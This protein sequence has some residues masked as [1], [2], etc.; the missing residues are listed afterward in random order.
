MITPPVGVKPMLVSIDFPA[1]NGTA[2]GEQRFS[3]GVFCL[4]FRA[5]IAD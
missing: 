3:M 1:G 5:L 2:L 4:E